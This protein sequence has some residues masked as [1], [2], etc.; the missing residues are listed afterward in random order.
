[1]WTGDLATDCFSFTTHATF[2]GASYS[3]EPSPQTSQAEAAIPTN[4]IAFAPPESLKNTFQ[5][6]WMAFHV[7][8]EDSSDLHHQQTADLLWERLG[9]A[10][11]NSNLWLFRVPPKSPNIW[12]PDIAASG[13]KRRGWGHRVSGLA[14][15]AGIQGHGQIM[16]DVAG[17]RLKWGIIGG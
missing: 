9:E 6:V 10:I 5:Y 12:P 17:T 11:S 15:W 13:S 4:L 3:P 8:G 1:M 14:D 2:L 16:P 7:G